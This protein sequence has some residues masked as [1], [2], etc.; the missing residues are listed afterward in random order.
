MSLQVEEFVQEEEEA[1]VAKA[2]SYTASR[3]LLDD[4]VNDGFNSKLFMY[5]NIPRAHLAND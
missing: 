3:Q 1:G 5:V 4:L 2:D